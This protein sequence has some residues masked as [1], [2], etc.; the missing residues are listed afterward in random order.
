MR[1][2]LTFVVFAGL[3]LLYFYQ[4]EHGAAPAENSGRSTL[5]APA[6]TA[7]APRGEA[8][9]HNYMKRALDRAATVRDDARHQTEAAQ[10]P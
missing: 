5:T 3:G 7:A 1:S 8:S 10:E 2:L 6:K 9:E 4:R